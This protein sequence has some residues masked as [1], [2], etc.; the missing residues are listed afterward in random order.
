MLTGEDDMRDEGA[1]ASKGRR[2]GTAEFR[3]LPPGHIPEKEA[4]LLENRFVHKMTLADSAFQAGFLARN[5]KAATETAARIV[6][7]HT[8]ENSEFVK[9]LDRVGVNVEAL[10]RVIAEGLQAESPLKQG[11]EVV[12]VPD[13]DTRHKY[14]Q[15][16][17]DILGAR[18]KKRVEVES[19]TF[20]QR[21]AA[22]TRGDK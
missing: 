22:L 11:S 21:L 3:N 12:M 9:G 4:R 8:R 1:R 15:T 17:L 10:A 20:E 14:V 16:G 7:R 19:L 5:R 18:A 6:R 13:H 2:Q